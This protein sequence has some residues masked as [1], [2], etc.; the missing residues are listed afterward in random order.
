M[1]ELEKGTDAILAYFRE[2]G[3]EARIELTDE[4]CG[5]IGVYRIEAEQ[6]GES[7]NE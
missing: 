2:Q 7:E 6:R 4:I 1:A 3:V 5:I